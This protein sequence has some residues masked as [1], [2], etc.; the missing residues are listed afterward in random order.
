MKKGEG[1]KGILRGSRKKVPRRWRKY[2]VKKEKKYEG[3]EVTKMEEGLR[4]WGVGGPGEGRKFWK[5]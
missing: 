3:R 5:G 4:R 2:C 1:G